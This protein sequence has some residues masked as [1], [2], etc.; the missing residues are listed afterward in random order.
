[1]IDS[2]LA[3]RHRI[4][5]G[6]QLD[7][8][9]NRLRVVG[10]SKSNGFMLSYVF[11]THRAL[12][13]FTGTADTTSFIVVGTADPE[14]VA[15]RLRAGGLH[16]LSRDEVAAN[17]VKFATGIFASPLRLMVGIG[18]AAGTMIIALTAY[19]T[20]IERR[21]EYGIIKAMGATR[22]RLVTIALVQTLTL[23]FLGLGAGLALFA[24]GKSIIAITRPQFTVLLTAGALGRAVG[25][26][27]LMAFVAAIVPARRLAALEPA[28]A[29][30]SAS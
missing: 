5:V 7:V 13:R 17:N 16:V 24:G 3:R 21:R 1:V 11:V 12:N 18:L 30:R 22:A 25:A 29:Y 10:L 15:E 23:S 4:A 8:M 2:V 27:V 26:A 19:T 20:I 6:D 14:A 9:G 28:I